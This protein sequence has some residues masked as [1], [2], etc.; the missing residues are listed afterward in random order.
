MP[1]YY[2]CKKLFGSESLKKA[3]KA[4]RD[5]HKHPDGEWNEVALETIEWFNAQTDPYYDTH[6]AII[7]ERYSGKRVFPTVTRMHFDMGYSVNSIN[8]R[9]QDILMTCLYFAYRKGLT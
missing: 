8:Y 4:M 6:K 9:D 3:R 7:H 5:C 1:T 2:H